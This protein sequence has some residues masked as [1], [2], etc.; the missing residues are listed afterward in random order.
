[1]IFF[2]IYKLKIL[3]NRYKRLKQ[4]KKLFDKHIL[5]FMLNKYKKIIYHRLNN[6]FKYQNLT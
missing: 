5:K 6:N 2:Y 4:K 1:M 3:K